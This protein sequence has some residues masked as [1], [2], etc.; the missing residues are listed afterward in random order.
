MAC[1]FNSFNRRNHQP[2]P[3]VPVSPEVMSY[4]DRIKDSKVDW[5]TVV[6]ENQETEQTYLQLARGVY[7]IAMEQDMIACSG[8][9]AVSELTPLNSCYTPVKPAFKPRHF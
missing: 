4:P 5:A 8:I 2:E 9:A 6:A 7:C 3:V 1:N